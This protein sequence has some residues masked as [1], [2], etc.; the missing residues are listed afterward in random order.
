MEDNFRKEMEDKLLIKEKEMEDKFKRE[1]EEQKQ[2]ILRLEKMM[3]T[4]TQE[5]INK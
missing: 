2:K 5:N 1:M 4:K 3:L